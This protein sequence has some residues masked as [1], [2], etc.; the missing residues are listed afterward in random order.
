MG[1]R[2]R[3]SV[4][5]APGVKLNFSKKGVGISAGVKG[6]RVTKGPTGRVTRTVSIP[7][8]GIYN[9]E[10][11]SKGKSEKRKVKYTVPA[12]RRCWFTILMLIFFYPVGI[13]TMWKYMRWNNYVKIVIT[14]VFAIATVFYLL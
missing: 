5:I 3:K 1:W 10:T 2:Y 6:F 11:I 13:F 4:K 9:T 12:Y 14:A 8:T 7:G